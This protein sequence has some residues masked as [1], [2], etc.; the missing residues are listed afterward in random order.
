MNLPQH[1]RPL[2]DLVVSGASVTWCVLLL[3]AAGCSSTDKN[4][5][6]GPAVEHGLEAVPRDVSENG[7]VWDKAVGGIDVVMSSGSLRQFRPG[8]YVEKRVSGEPAVLHFADLDG[9]TLDLTGVELRGQAADADL[10]EAVG[11]GIRLLNCKNVTLKGA[12]L[13]GFK[14]CLAIENCANVTVTDVICDG[15][16]GQRLR[17]TRYAEDL[18]DWL[19][20]HEN[21]A[22]EWETNYGAGISA[23]DS[24]EVTI[25]NCRGRRGQNGILL[26][27]VTGSR[28]FDNDFSFLSGWGLGMYRSTGNV[29]SR[30][31]FD[32]CV[33]GFS[34]DVYWRGQDSAG[35]LM[36]ERCSDN[37][38]AYNSA[39]HGG[40]GV[41]LYG[42]N[43]I[44]ERGLSD[45]TGS[46]N[47]LFLG[48]DLR[49][50]VAN[51]LEATFSRGNAVIDN[52]LSG[53][54]QHGI[55]GGYS[56]EMLITG[57]KVNDTIGAAITIEHGQDCV[58]A[59]N[60]LTRNEIGVELYW[61]Q[62]PA[63]VEGPFGRNND[64]RSRDHWVLTNAFSSNVLD[65]VVRQT[66]GLIF[67]G[68]EYTPGTRE[69]YFEGVSSDADAT[70]DS[71]TVQRWLDALDGSFP[72][73]NLSA[74]TLNPWIGRDPQLLT[75]WSS[76]KH[77]DFPGT[78]ETS[79]EKRDEFRGG[80]ESIVMGEWG[81]WDFRSG[82]P[83][84]KEVKPGGL[85]AQST[86]NALW[87]LWKPNGSDPR[88]S[89]RAWRAR[90]NSPILRSEVES[91]INPWASED[92]RRLIGND[93]FGLFAATTIQV[94]EPGTF[95][96]SV[97]SDDGIRVYV[98]EELV[99]EDWT[100][101]A[102]QQ[103]ERTLQ[104]DRGEHIIRFE[105]FQIQGAAALV[106][107]LRAH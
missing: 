34:H 38:L 18:S 93:F 104:L 50:A 78:Q 60:E 66:T 74:T 101:H 15:W 45:A 99:I 95:D 85:L 94:K 3:A 98:D 8:T 28:V 68:N 21:D 82:A 6:S 69:P 70:L 2:R 7:Q 87:F 100:L 96:L 58:I 80:L 77:G 97:V 79:A 55:W 4:E 13:G 52:Q 57:N 43:D 20:P 83:R 106:V 62:D 33:R 29:I 36:F 39:T 37:V 26:T 16:F 86:W 46:D 103:N 102:P 105:Y 31:V 81:A 75:K 48:N 1:N 23:S 53:S 32:Y 76:M 22:L 30:N 17:S 11:V 27:R 41:F 9:L 24:S 44:V 5:E 35:I 71:T 49:Y 56:S 88:T 89:E 64:T 25:R 72:S 92:N 14:V 12:K 67:H 61:D 63:L 10:D 90:A 84:P 59:D 73:G 47:N 91:F 54:H 42:G 107:A 19:R 40:D 65:L 51:S